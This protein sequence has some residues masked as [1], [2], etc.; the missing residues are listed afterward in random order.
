MNGRHERPLTA[1]AALRNIA[2][3]ALERRKEKARL[4]E[5]DAGQHPIPLNR[6][7]GA[8]EA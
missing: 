6:R 3:E 1:T 4:Q 8:T 5:E 7:S 2:R